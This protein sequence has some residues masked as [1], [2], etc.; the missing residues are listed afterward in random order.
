MKLEEYWNLYPEK[1]PDVI[2]VNRSTY[3]VWEWDWILYYLENYY[4]YDRVVS[5]EY[6]D[7]YFR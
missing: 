4:H 1:Y 7:F 6:A 3:H 2:A 5:T